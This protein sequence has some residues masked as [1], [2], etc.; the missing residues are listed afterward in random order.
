VYREVLLLHSDDYIV[1]DHQHI[2]C[3]RSGEFIYSVYF[4]LRA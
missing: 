4:I 1:F 2:S 3:S